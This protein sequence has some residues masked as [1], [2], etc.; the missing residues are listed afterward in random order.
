MER[1]TAQ[2]ICV[3]TNALHGNNAFALRSEWSQQAVNHCK[4]TLR[5]FGNSWHGASI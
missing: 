2:F 1:K 3:E 5:A 4:S